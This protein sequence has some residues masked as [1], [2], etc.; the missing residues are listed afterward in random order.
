MSRLKSFYHALVPPPIRYPIGRFRRGLLDLGR[1]LATRG[2][3]PP[4]QL[5]TRVQLTPWIGEYLEIGAKAAAAIRGILA[6]AVPG[7]GPRVLDFGCGLGRVLRHFGDVAAADGGWELHGC[8]VDPATLAWSRRAF[9]F[10]HLARSGEEPPLPYPASRF[11]AVYAVS[12]FSH[13]DAA[14]QRRWAAELARVL[15]PAGLAVITTMG[16]RAF[17]SFPGLAT[18]A[19]RRRLDGEGF[20]FY[21]GEGDPPAFN[22]RGAFHTAAGLEGFFAGGFELERWI[23]GGLDGFQDLAVFRRRQLVPEVG[24]EPTRP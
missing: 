22:A 21:P 3:L 11:D 8:D 14:E 19:N 13:F 24:V 12:V 1:R 7:N 10:A 15:A 2:P 4:R 18:A 16:P 17:G 5:L 23:E 20:F 9:P 6:A